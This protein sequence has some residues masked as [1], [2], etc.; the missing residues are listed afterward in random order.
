MAQTFIVCFQYQEL[1]STI[2]HFLIFQTQ[3]SL[4]L[5]HFILLNIHLFQILLIG[6][7]EFEFIL[8]LCSFQK[9]YPFLNL[10]KMN[11]SILLWLIHI[12]Y[13]IIQFGPLIFHLWYLMIFLWFLFIY[14]CLKIFYSLRNLNFIYNLRFK[15][16]QN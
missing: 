15:G 6:L 1:L 7:V 3:L 10:K 14:L 11:C 2:L 5:H 16:E 12:N 13:F 4:S 8:C 9:E